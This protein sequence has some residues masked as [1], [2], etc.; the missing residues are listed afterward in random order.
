MMTIGVERLPRALMVRF[1]LLAA[2]FSG[3]AACG[4]AVEGDGPAAAPDVPTYEG[5]IDI[6]IGKL[7]GD[8]PYLFSDIMDVV[9]DDAGRVIVVDRQASEIRVFEPDGDFAFSFGGPGEGPG[10]LSEPSR[11]QFGPDGELWVRESVRYSVFRLDAANAEF[12]RV[13]R[14]LTPGHIGVRDQF[15]FDGDGQ[16]VAIGPVRGADDASLEARLRLGHDG[17]VDTVILADSERQGAGQKTVPFTRGNVRGRV[18]LHAPF[19]PRWIRAHANGGTWAEAVSTE[20]A[21]NYHGPDGTVSVIR[22]PADQGPAPGQEE[23]TRAERQLE[24]ELD[25]AGLDRHP[26]DIPGRK[27]PLARI[28]FDQAGRLWVRKTAAEGAAMHEADVYE[29]TTLAARYRWPSGIQDWPDPRVFDSVLYG[30]TADSLGVERV[31][32]VR[33]TPVN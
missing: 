28:F 18:Y 17:V 6:E 10:E 22:G 8:D 3:I 12:K 29:G 5:A 1:G 9:A 16:L 11:L 23:R 27:P 21:I 7:D 4:E 19:G 25:R 30:V 26:F 24:R 32:R 31:A 13:L 20:Y 33:F 2:L 15:T 14:S